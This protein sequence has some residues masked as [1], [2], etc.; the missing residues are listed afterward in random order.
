MKK[1]TDANK[2]DMELL[3]SLMVNGLVRPEDVV[4]AAKAEDHPWHE[5]FEW[6]DAAAA[7]KHRLDTARQIIRSVHVRIIRDEVVTFRPAFVRSPEE[8]DTVGYREVT[9][10]ANQREMAAAVL[11]DELARIRGNIERARSLAAE[12]GLADEMERL[13][14][15][16]VA[17]AQQLKMAA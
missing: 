13:L 14:G 1:Q 9:Q 3:Q 11:D 15:S 7:E 8:Q 17:I 5:R 4:D 10:V 12:F 16:L 6:D 2:R